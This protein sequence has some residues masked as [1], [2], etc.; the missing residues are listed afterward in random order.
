MFMF[1]Y[2]IFPCFQ[3]IFFSPHLVQLCLVPIASGTM[4]V[5]LIFLF[6]QMLISCAIYVFYGWLKTYTS[7]KKISISKPGKKILF[8]LQN[9]THNFIKTFKAQV[10]TKYMWTQNI[11]YLYTLI[12]TLARNFNALSCW[13][14]HM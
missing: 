14:F 9:F 3:T 2:K 8:D 13:H 4:C 11:F 5:Y 12:Y 10:G 7:M 1:I 6:Y